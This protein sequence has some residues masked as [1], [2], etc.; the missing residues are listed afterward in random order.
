[1]TDKKIG[2]GSRYTDDMQSEDLRNEECKIFVGNVP[3]QCTQE[4]FARCFQNIKGFIKAEI[5]TVYKTN[6]SR[7]FGFVTMR[8]LH[9]AEN[10]KQRYDILFKGRV[11][12]FTSYQNE[13]AK[14]V[15]ETLNNHVFIDGIPEGKNRDW[16]RNY[17]NSYEPIGRCFITMNHKNGELKNNGVIEIIDDDKYKSILAIKWH[18]NDGVILETSKYRPNLPHMFGMMDDLTLSQSH[19]HNTGQVNVYNNMHNTYRQDNNN[20]FD[21]SIKRNKLEYCDRNF[22][23]VKVVKKK[24][25]NNNFWHKTIYCS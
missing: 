11:L 20:K 7:G 15:T 12:R 13:N 17:F 19:T 24:S 8:T 16:L 23:S 10:L 21:H 6:M 14:P 2:Y 1:M 25:N 22:G 4:E 18:E 5:M 9:D 3:Y